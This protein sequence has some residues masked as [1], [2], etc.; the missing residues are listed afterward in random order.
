MG[1]GVDS[2]TVALVA[3]CRIEFLGETLSD[4]KEIYPTAEDGRITT[5]IIDAARI[6]RD[7][8]FE[9][10][11]EGKGATVTAQFGADGITIVDPNRASDGPDAVFEKIYD[12]PV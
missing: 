2:I 1:Y 9:Y 12:K 8:N 6:V 5:A 7:R 4:V 11:R 3:I 10:M